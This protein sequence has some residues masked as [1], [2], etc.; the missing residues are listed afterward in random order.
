MG[1]AAGSV[2][3]RATHLLDDVEIGTRYDENFDALCVP[4]VRRRVEW[5]LAALHRHKAQRITEVMEVCSLGQ[6]LRRPTYIRID[7]VHVSLHRDKA[8]ELLRILGT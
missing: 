8:F 2:V 7:T 5:R 6:L 4:V 1:K 3:S